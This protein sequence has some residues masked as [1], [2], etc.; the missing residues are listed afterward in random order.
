M[1]A[2]HQLVAAL[3]LVAF[4]TSAE[5][6][7]ALCHTLPPKIPAHD[8]HNKVHGNWTL[9]WAVADYDDGNELLK[10]LNNSHVELD[11]HTHDDTTDII[12]NERNMFSDKACT[13]Y[14]MKMTNMSASSSEDALKFEGGVKEVDGNVTEM[15]NSVTI[16]FY[17]TC[18]QEC[19]MMVVCSWGSG[20]FVLG[21]KM[22]G[23]LGGEGELQKDQNYFKHQAELLGF[24]TEKAFCHQGEAEGCP[25]KPEPAVDS[26]H[27]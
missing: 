17:E 6:A 8:L 9:V 27:A 25:K 11:F 24:N 10:K 26:K 12:F 21:Y 3:L 7:A 18:P 15:K 2:L 4:S 16:E 19:C 22:E 14:W 5:P 20:R 1:T 23:K 13:Y